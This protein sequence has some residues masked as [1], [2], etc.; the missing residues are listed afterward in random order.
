MTRK[1][2][3]CKCGECGKT[4]KSATDRSA[5][6]KKEHLGKG[7]RPKRDD[8]ESTREPDASDPKKQNAAKKKIKNRVN[9][10]EKETQPSKKVRYRDEESS[11]ADSDFQPEADSDFQSDDES[12]TTIST[13]T[14][15]DA[16]RI[17]LGCRSDHIAL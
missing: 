11:A 5:H 7:P 17:P 6:W 15:P 8:D 3:S 12:R 9:R 2:K 14:H 13:R 1:C 16:R 4:F 10:A